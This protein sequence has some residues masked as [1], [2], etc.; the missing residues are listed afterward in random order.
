M[1][2]LT[3]LLSVS[4][5]WV[6]CYQFHIVEFSVIKFRYVEFSLLS[7][8]KYVVSDHYV[9]VFQMV[10]ISHVILL[11]LLLK[12]CL[13]SVLL[14]FVVN[15]DSI[16]IFSWFCIFIKKKKSCFI[17]KAK[18]TKYNFFFLKAQFPVIFVEI[19]PSILLSFRFIFFFPFVDLFV[20]F[21][22]FIHAKFEII[23]SKKRKKERK[24]IIFYFKLLFFHQ[25]I[26]TA[27]NAPSATRAAKKINF[28]GGCT[29]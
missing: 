13:L 3:F 14:N 9:N 20:S 24:F 15:F 1:F 23:S 8:Q 4:F 28:F 19:V 27:E 26:L 16:F 22:F 29:K 7:N 6:F 21:F 17:E 10:A 5:R 12:I 11:I 2:S 25:I 18:L